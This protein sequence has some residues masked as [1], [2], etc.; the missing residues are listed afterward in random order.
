MTT[1]TASQSVSQEF[2]SSKQHSLGKFLALHLLP[3]V[4]GTLAYIIL[5]PIITQNGYP[6]VLGLL[7]AAGFII[8]PI[9]L[10]ILFYQARRTTGTFSL[11][12]ILP[13]RDPLP[14]WQYL[15]IPLG[16]VVW[17]FVATF[18]ISM[19]ENAIAKAWFGWL[20]ERFFFFDLNQYEGYARSALMLT[21][22][23]YFVVNGVSLPIVEELYFRG[24]LLPHLERFGKWAPL[25]NASLFSLYHFWTPWGTIS[26]ILWMFP[27]IYVSWRKRNIYLIMIAHITANVIGTLLTWGLIL[28][29]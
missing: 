13:Y 14:K 12:K 29:Q 19:L 16:L 3:G 11:K 21:F 4:A 9:E 27:W 24:Y 18:F 17:I 8:L 22:I 2:V 15:I 25:I 5:A 20:P 1:I 26:R 23:V 7:V 6:A 10:G 28:G